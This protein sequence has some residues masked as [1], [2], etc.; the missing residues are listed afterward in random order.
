MRVLLTSFAHNTHYHG[1]VPLAWALRS[2]GHEVRVASQPALAETIT[3]SG[4]TAVPV[5][6]D[7]LIVQ[8]RI[9]M[10][11]EPR[12]THPAFQFHEART[13][14]FDWED[15]LG[16][17]TLLTAFYYAVV[18]NDAM[19][20]DMV[21]FA[22]SWRPDLVLWE[23]T[24][25]AGP[26]AARASGAAHARVLWCPDV[27]GSARR[28]FLALQEQ[29]H[30]ARREDPL[31][32]WL[33]WTLARYGCTFAEEVTVGQWTVDPTPPSLR[34]PTGLPTLGMRYVPYNGRSVVPDWLR[35]PP[36]RPRVCL[37]LG[38]SAR[39]VLGGDGVSVADLVNGLADLDIE[40]VATL[41]TA[42][43]EELG[44]LP[45]NV[46]LVDFVPMH[47][48]LPTCSS[49]VHHGG[50]GT[51]ATA[52]NYGVPQVMVAE[53]WDAP[54]KA[55]AVE[56]LGAGVFVPPAELTTDRV[57]EAVERTLTEPS[58]A[59]AAAARPPC[60]LAE[61]SPAALVPQLELLTAQ[62]R[63]TDRTT[64]PAR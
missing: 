46:R 30:P 41:D 48:L 37:T 49:I 52:V 34:L 27:V 22:R 26:V 12:P 53:L 6:T 13:G 4:L 25:Y 61:P 3:E 18:N 59:Q 10:A 21:S 32:E 1:L 35:T 29:E 16:L 9:Q 60:R 56:K 23:P 36:R 2:A 17:D 62:H 47:V 50:A 44:R 28:K 33:T 40:L 31:A 43:R 24:T 57:R 54:V 19:I 63:G 7:H 45:E 20:D 15:A 64:G 14:A 38:V 55:R 11:G 51:Y 42:Q 58:F 5:G 8:T 39:E